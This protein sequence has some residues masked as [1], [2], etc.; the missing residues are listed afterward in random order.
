MIIL[1]K[2]TDL[3][4]LYTVSCHYGEGIV[5]YTYREMASFFLVDIWMAFSQYELLSLNSNQTKHG[6][7]YIASS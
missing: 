2:Y 1:P 3:F 6:S 5:M 4:S 7:P